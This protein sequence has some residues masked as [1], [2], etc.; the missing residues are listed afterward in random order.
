ML[1]FGVRLNR[2]DLH[3]HWVPGKL[4]LVPMVI[5]VL[6]VAHS[7]SGS[8]LIGILSWDVLKSTFS[9]EAKFQAILHAIDF[10]QFH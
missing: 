10:L 1:L 4:A 7:P 3:K 8:K 2:M 6:W 9:Y 5:L